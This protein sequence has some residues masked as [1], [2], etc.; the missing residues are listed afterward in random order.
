[1]GE[2]L[3]SF[4]CRVAR[5]PPSLKESSRNVASNVAVLRDGRVWSGNDGHRRKDDVSSETA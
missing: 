5:V 3:D 1:M 2:E 4:E